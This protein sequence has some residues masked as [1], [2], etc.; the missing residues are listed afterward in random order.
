MWAKLN[1]ER[2]QCNTWHIICTLNMVLVVV[3]WLLIMNRHQNKGGSWEKCFLSEVELTGC[4]GKGEEG[5]LENS[6]V[7]GLAKSR[8]GRGTGVGWVGECWGVRKTH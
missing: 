4:W 7:S 6:Q 1:N 3:V 5:I 2:I 8:G